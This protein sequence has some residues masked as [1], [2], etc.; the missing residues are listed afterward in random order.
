MSRLRV[1]VCGSNYA[2]TYIT[3]LA[4]EPRK[5]KLAGILARGSDR[6]QHLAALSGVPLY[7][8]ADDLP[9]NIDLACA[10][11]SSAAWPV[12]LELIR[13]GIHVLCEHPYPAGA[14]QTALALARKHNVQFHVNG[15]F[16]DLPAPQAFIRDCR[17]NI[18]FA[19]PEFV[20]VMATERSLY[21]TLDILMAAIGGP[22]LQIRVSSRPSQFVLLDGTMG[23]LPVQ[24]CVQVSGTK[25][26]GRLPDGSP[27]YL[28]DHRLTVMF[29][30]GALSLLSMAGPV[31]WNST[32]AHVSGNK[33]SLW[34][35]LGARETRTVAGLREQ[36]ILANVAALKSIRKS[37][38]GQG[39][40]EM[41]QPEHILK[42]SK[43]WESIGRQLYSV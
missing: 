39:T 19:R 1:L 18:E 12:V 11:M 24:V 43:A 25:G 8:S 20:D 32:L 15:H 23:K 38:M 5:Y 17:R 22:P 7:R 42:V 9:N 29:P 40:P 36:R 33:D 35:L 2:R 37:I 21:A 13:R 27:S 6:S 10:A 26:A 31:I 4:K 3:A 28:L 34:T 30:A 16:A 41:Q 14:L